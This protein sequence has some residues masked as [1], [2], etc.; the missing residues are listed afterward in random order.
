[1]PMNEFLLDFPSVAMEQVAEVLRMA[2]TI[3]NQPEKLDDVLRDLK[4]LS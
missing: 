2:G 3:F 4:E 1:M